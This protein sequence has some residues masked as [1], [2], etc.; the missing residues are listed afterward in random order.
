MK[1]LLV[2]ANDE[3]KRALSFHLRPIGVEVI[4]YVHPIKAMDNIEEIEPDVVLFSSSDFP[5]HWKPFLKLLR[6]NKARNESMF[7]LLRGGDFSRSMGS[8]P[9]TKAPSA[10]FV[11]SKRSWFATA[12]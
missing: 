2:A 12:W 7:I 8:S 11:T 3:L 5:R 9:R 6:G 10:S 4:Q 1:L